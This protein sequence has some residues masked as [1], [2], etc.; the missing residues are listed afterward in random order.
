M[1]TRCILC[2]AEHGLCLVLADCESFHC[3]ECGESFDVADLEEH[4]MQLRKL[5]CVSRAAEKE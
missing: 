2:N 1:T 5:V 4:I 3:K